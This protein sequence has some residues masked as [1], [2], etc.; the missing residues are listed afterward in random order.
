MSGLNMRSSKST[1][2]DATAGGA[3]PTARGQSLHE[4]KT[5]NSSSWQSLTM[6]SSK[7]EPAR[8][9]RVARVASRGQ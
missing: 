2:I 3:T 6:C 8:E 9:S 5:D 7:S 1:S 4:E